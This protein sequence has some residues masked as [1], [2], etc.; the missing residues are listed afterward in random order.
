MTN[1]QKRSRQNTDDSYEDKDE[2][3][4]VAGSEMQF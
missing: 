3:R 4:N 1:L 2:Q